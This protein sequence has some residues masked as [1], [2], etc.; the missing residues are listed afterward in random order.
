VDVSWGTDLKSKQHLVVHEKL[1]RMI[2]PKHHDKTIEVRTCCCV[3]RGPVRCECWM[4]KNAYMSGE[5]AQMHVKVDNNSEV[6]VNHFNSKLI[7]EIDIADGHGHTK[8]IRDVISMRKYDGTP[9][10]TNRAADIPL[11]LMGKKGKPIK[12]A[13]SSRLIKCHYIIMVEMDI[14]WAPDLEIYSPVT[15]YAPQNPLWVNWSAPAWISQAQVQQVCTQVAVPKEIIDVRLN[16]GY[17]APP[18]NTVNMSFNVKPNAPF[19][20][21]MNVT[22]TVKETT[23]LLM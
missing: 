16:S 10:H 12:P 1:D 22:I 18:P 2:E 13:T 14:P 20:P 5:T 11:P 19:D 4:D 3:P 17:F 23:P 21:S 8:T 9:P 6:N 15:I 7:R